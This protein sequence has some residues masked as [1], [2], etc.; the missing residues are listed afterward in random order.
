MRKIVELRAL[1]S[2]KGIDALLI[3]KQENYFYLTGMSGE[4]SFCVV[5]HQKVV[6]IVDFRF[7]SQAKAQAPDCEVFEYSGDVFATLN[8]MFHDLGV[9][10]IGYDPESTTCSRF[11]QAEKKIFN[12]KFIDASGLLETLRICKSEDEMEII[13]K[14][15]GIADSAFSSSLPFIRPG[16]AELDVAAEIEYRMR[17]LGASGPSFETIVASGARGA[18]PHGVASEKI[19]KFGEAVTIDFGAVYNGYCSDMTRTVFVGTP[20]PQMKRIY[21]IVLVAQKNALAGCLAK[22]TSRE[23][24]AIARGIISQAGFGENFGHGTGHGVGVEIHEAPRLNSRS[25]IE[26]Q[27][28]M[29]VTVEPGIYLPDVGGVRIE[30]MVL[31]GEAGPIIL[32]QTTKEMLVI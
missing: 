28:G 5:T 7:T 24:D 26:L 18:L 21:E 11:A 17:K 25:E 23:V 15:V 27:E 30:D 16:V 14:A 12:V 20:K 8:T 9:S 31:I 10:R 19:I 29:V 3:E 4:D 6:M 32:T 2:E 13:K 22:A 1:M